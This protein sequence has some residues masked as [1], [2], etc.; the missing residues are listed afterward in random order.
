MPV[1]RMRLGPPSNHTETPRSQVVVDRFF[2]L[3]AVRIAA[4]RSDSSLFSLLVRPF[5]HNSAGH[6]LHELRPIPIL[7]ETWE[8]RELVEDLRSR[9]EPGDVADKPGGYDLDGD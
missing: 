7:R 1:Q 6:V 5:N 3:M 9:E 2:P 8:A 4:F